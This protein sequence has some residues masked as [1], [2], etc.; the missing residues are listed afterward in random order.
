MLAVRPRRRVHEDT[1]TTYLKSKEME[2]HVTIHDMPKHNGV[3]EHLNWTLVKHM[4]TM[5]YT[6]DLSKNLWGEAATH[7][8]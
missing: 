7:A 4:C 2:C 6:A 1:F 3:A 5:I 8:I